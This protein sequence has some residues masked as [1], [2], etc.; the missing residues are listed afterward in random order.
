MNND[1]L[2]P[3]M[4]QEPQRFNPHNHHILK[5][6]LSKA[7]DQFVERECLSWA[8]MFNYHGQQVC[9]GADGYR[10][11]MSWFAPGKLRQQSKKGSSDCRV[12]P[13][14][15]SEGLKDAKKWIPKLEVSADKVLALVNPTVCNTYQV[16]PN[17]MMAA[18]KRVIYSPQKLFWKIPL[19]FADN[20]L[21][22]SAEEH[23]QKIGASGS[24]PFTGAYNPVYLLDALWIHHNKPLVTIHVNTGEYPIMGIGTTGEQMAVIMPFKNN[25]VNGDES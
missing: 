4:S 15:F 2:I 20:I 9:M 19:T 10:L 1:T 11:H 22:L 3:R 5:T 8:Y 23:T 18:L 6:W 17:V 7:A 25:N 14:K 21:T 16:N 12:V 13:L 24:D